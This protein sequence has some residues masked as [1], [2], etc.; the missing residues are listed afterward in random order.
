MFTRSTVLPRLPLGFQTAGDVPDVSLPFRWD[1]S[2]PQT[3]TLIYL[4]ISSL[5]FVIVWLVGYLR[6]RQ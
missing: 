2:N 5:A 3:W 1:V 6:A 4:A